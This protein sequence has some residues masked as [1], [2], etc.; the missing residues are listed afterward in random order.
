M[1]LLRC[2]L[3]IISLAVTACQTK[4]K[5]SSSLKST[6]VVGTIDCKAS[7]EVSGKS[8]TYEVTA[9]N[10]KNDFAPQAKMI[11]NRDDILLTIKSGADTIANQVGKGEGVTQAAASATMSVFIYRKDGNIF[12]LSFSNNN[13]TLQPGIVN[14]DLEETTGPA[15]NC[16]LN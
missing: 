2:F 16:T 5:S 6:P 4:D 11:V 1:T 7:F 10:I 14:S 13:A 8:Y 15:A 12:K 9:G 3:V